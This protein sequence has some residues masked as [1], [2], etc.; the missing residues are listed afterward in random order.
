MIARVGTI[1]D[2]VN[3]AG[4]TIHDVKWGMEVMF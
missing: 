3:N 1:D 4:R 2:G